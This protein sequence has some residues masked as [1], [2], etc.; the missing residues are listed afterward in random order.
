VARGLI[1]RL[2]ASVAAG[3]LLGGAILLGLRLSGGGTGPAL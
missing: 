2:V 3:L 1:L